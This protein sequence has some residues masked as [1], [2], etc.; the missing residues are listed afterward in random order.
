MLT[1]IEL[2]VGFFTVDDVETIGHSHMHAAHLKVEPLVVVI[3]VDV[4]VQHQVILKPAEDIY[5]NCLEILSEISSEAK[6]NNL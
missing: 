1:I 3:T 2:A 6:K 5:I 4:R